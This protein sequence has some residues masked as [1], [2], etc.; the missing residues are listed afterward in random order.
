MYVCVFSG[1]TFNSVDTWL[2]FGRNLGDW[3]AYQNMSDSKGDDP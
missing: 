1:Q 2:D 3:G